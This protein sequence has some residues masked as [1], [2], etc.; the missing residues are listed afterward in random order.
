MTGT[1]SSPYCAAGSLVPCHE[2][3]GRQVKYELLTVD[4]WDT[5]L[6][7]RCHPDGVKLHV[8]RYLLLKWGDRLD[9]VCRDPWILLRLRQQAEKEIGDEKQAQG[10]DDEY[11]HLDVYRRW[12][13]LAGFEFGGQVPVL[14]ENLLFELDRAEIGKKKQVS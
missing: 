2:E 7:R 8:C 12:L 3:A 9:P 13:D 10:F 6:R 4:V 11:G 5:L 14:L 1:C